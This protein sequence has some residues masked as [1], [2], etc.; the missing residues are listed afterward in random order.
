MAQWPSVAGE[1]ARYGV[2]FLFSAVSF[3]IILRCGGRF[4]DL[5]ISIF[6]I[7]FLFEGDP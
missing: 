1:I 3:R 4:K 6:L 7:P 5:T 2:Y